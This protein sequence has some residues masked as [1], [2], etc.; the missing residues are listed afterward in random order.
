VVNHTIG[1]YEIV[2]VLHEGSTCTLYVARDAELER[3]VVIKVLNNSQTLDDEVKVRFLREA[4]SAAVLEHPNIC[5]I[6]ALRSTS[7]GLH[8]FVMPLYRGETLR[9][10]LTRHTLTIDQVLSIAQQVAHA[11]GHAHGH[12]V[13]HRDLKPENVF[14]TAEALVKLLDFGVAKLGNDN[15]TR[16]GSLMGTVAYMAPE[17]IQGEPASVQTD[18]WAWGTMFFEMLS[19]RVP[20]ADAQGFDMMAAI[21]DD[22]VPALPEQVLGGIAT[23]HFQPLLQLSLAKDPQQR[24]RSMREIVEWLEPLIANRPHVT[25]L[26]M[27]LAVSTVPVWHKPFVGR[28]RELSQLA[29]ELFEGAKLLTLSGQAGVGKTHMALAVLYGPAIHVLFPDGM[30]HVPVDTE[31]DDKAF[32]P[33]VQGI[34]GQAFERF[35]SQLADSLEH[36][37]NVDI[38]R[39]APIIVIQD[40]QTGQS[41]PAHHNWQKNQGR[42][43]GQQTG[44]SLPPHQNGQTGQNLQE[45]HNLHVMT[46]AALRE[47][48]RLWQQA[49]ALVVADKRVL[50]LIDGLHRPLAGVASLLE[51]LTQFCPQLVILTTARQRLGVPSE[52]VF[53]LQ[54]LPI[55]EGTHAL[56]ENPAA[57]M[58]MRISQRTHQPTNAPLVLRLCQLLGGWPAALELAAQWHA[59]R[60]CQ[61]LVKAAETFELA[62]RQGLLGLTDLLE[63]MWASLNWQEASALARLAS[64]GEHISLATASYVAEVSADLLMA[65][66]DKHML[67]RDSQQ[68]NNQQLNNQQ[69]DTYRV[70]RLIVRYAQHKLASAPTLQTTLQQRLADYLARRLMGIAPEQLLLTSS[71]LALPNNTPAAAYVPLNQV[72]WHNLP[73]AWQVWLERPPKRFATMMV[74]LSR[75]ASYVHKEATAAALLEQAQQQ[76]THYQRQLLA[77][78]N[79]SMRQQQQWQQLLQLRYVAALQA[80]CQYVRLGEIE[81][82]RRCFNALSQDDLHDVVSDITSIEVVLG[83][84]LEASQT[85]TAADRSQIAIDSL[86]GEDDVPPELNSNYDMFA[87]ESMLTEEDIFAE[88]DGIAAQRWQRIEVLR[89][90]EHALIEAILWLAEGQRAT[91][92]HSFRILMRHDGTHQDSIN[93]DGTHQ[94]SIHQDGNALWQLLTPAMLA[95][96]VILAAHFAS[97]E[98]TGMIVEQALASYRQRGDVWGEQCMTITQAFVSWGQGDLQEA[99]TS[100]EG[101]LEQT[102]CAPVATLQG[103]LL[104][105]EVRFEQGQWQVASQLFEQAHNQ[106]MRTPSAQGQAQAQAQAQGRGQGHLHVNALAGLAKVAS[107]QRDTIVAYAYLQQALEHAEHNPLR[108]LEAVAS[109]YLHHKA[110]DE[111]ALIVLHLA[112]YPEHRLQRDVGLDVP[113]PD[114]RLAQNIA[115]LLEQVRYLTA[116][117]TWTMLESQVATLSLETVLEQVRDDL[118]SSEYSF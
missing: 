103:N 106:L 101:V 89:A 115:A 110:I 63:T 67:E 47:R 91:A 79:L 111:A 13:I 109:V 7:D 51:Q 40:G 39:P 81:A 99:A 114:S 11:L 41:L 73:T 48:V 78:T 71:S 68:L 113:L 86:W 74:M 65:L 93:Q 75:R 28:E 70:N 8:Y 60:D 12:G 116:E 30:L 82:A 118:A 27:R 102:N 23:E 97:C 104:L 57:Q 53:L 22:P 6:F 38:D 43:I 50:L 5:S 49:L 95:K 33:P 94:D 88:G 55:P 35:A 36:N 92:E 2:Q 42:Q 100:L 69:H 16:A 96:S 29:S 98:K 77:S 117:D 3:D 14:V 26:P 87:A 59:Q 21:R 64:L 25:T 1:D 62:G 17:L 52:R 45:R 72:E 58:F 105:A 46:S 61:A 85:A 34:D 54:A 31:R 24:A 80:T 84:L 20:Y 112:S 76:F 15:I 10:N 4:R 19:G 9:D 107:A 18:I 108:V 90:L 66:L 44:Q 56:A 32:L 83:N 37:L